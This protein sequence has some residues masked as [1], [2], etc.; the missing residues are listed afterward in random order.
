MPESDRKTDQGMKQTTYVA[1]DAISFQSNGNVDDVQAAGVEVSPT[2]RVG[3]SNTASPPA[4]VT[5]SAPAIGQLKIDDCSGSMT[6]N[7]GRGHCE[8]QV[9][10][11][12]FKEEGEMT[13]RRLSVIECEK[14]QCFPPDF[15]KVPYRGKPAS[16]CK[17][18]PRY[19][20]IGNSMS[21]NVM[22]FLGERIQAVNEILATTQPEPLEWVEPTRKV[23]V[24][25]E[26][27]EQIGMF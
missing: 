9:S 14:L 4:V 11:F 16:E 3:S 8:T 10:A 27:H 20:A 22:E 13:V 15:T 1:Q 26:N 2:V 25:E 17:D 12:V 18:S 5:A 7:N 23:E 24:E 21:V 19:R 6:A